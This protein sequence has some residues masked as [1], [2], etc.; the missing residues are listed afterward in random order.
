M[1]QIEFKKSQIR[2][3]NVDVF[4]NPNGPIDQGFQPTKHQE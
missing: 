2:I 4:S 1:L 3:S